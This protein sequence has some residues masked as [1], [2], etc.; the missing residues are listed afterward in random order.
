MLDV[1]CIHSLV[2]PATLLAG[3]WEHFVQGRPEPHGAIAN[4]QSPIASFG[5][6]SPQDLRFNNTSRQ[7][8]VDSLTPSSMA[9]KCF[10]PRSFT[11]IITRAHSLVCSALS[12]L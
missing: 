3:F 9:R 8:W 2:H 4:R 11:P 10:S 12:P 5:T 7:L 1:L 6:F